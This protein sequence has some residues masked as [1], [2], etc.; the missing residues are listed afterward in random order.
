M[1][2]T[3][4][5][6]LRCNGGKLGSQ[7]E[8]LFLENVLD[9]VKD[10]DLGSVT[11]QMPFL[12]ADGRQRY[13]DF[14]IAEG[15]ELRIALEVDGYDKT[16]TGMGMS[17]QE[18]RDWQRRHVALVAQ[19]WDVLRFAN[20]DVR[21]YPDRCI[22]AIELLLREERQ[23]ASHRKALEKRIKELERVFRKQ[24]EVRDRPNANDVEQSGILERERQAKREIQRLKNELKSAKNT[25]PLSDKEQ[26][27]LKSVVDAQDKVLAKFKE[28]TDTMKHAIWAMAFVICTVVVVLAVSLSES[29]S[30]RSGTT[31]RAQ[32][33]G[34]AALSESVGDI[35]TETETPIDKT[36][37]ADCS[38]PLP[39]R[40]AGSYVGQNLSFV[41]VVHEVSYMPELDGEPTFVN[42]GASFPDTERLTAVIWGRNGPYFYDFIN[43]QPVGLTVCVSGKVESYRGTAQIELRSPAQLSVVGEW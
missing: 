7:Y 33:S 31:T 41:G 8:R 12:D 11:A 42:I 22:E 39:W 2:K 21:D 25:K 10:L 3:K 6:W 36:P 35:S 20:T 14:A 18:F 17:R 19:G 15:A 1:T 5:E 13:C 30:E 16:G 9:H 34:Q 29:A 27:R 32:N 23:K 40:R 28:E 37:G 26:E 4:T 43:S 38:E 24:Q